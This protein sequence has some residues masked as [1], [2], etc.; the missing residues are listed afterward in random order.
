[1]VTKELIAALTEARR[2]LPSDAWHRLAREL[3][4]FQ[5]NPDIE[6]IE[7][8]ASGIANPDAAWI[9]KEAF[10]ESANCTE[11]NE[12]AATMMSVDYFVGDGAES[13]E[14]IWTGPSNNRFPM[15]RIDQALYDLISA[16]QR[17]IILVTFA[18]HRVPYLCAHLV[19]AVGRGVDLTLIVESEGESEGQLTLDAIAAFRGVPAAQ[20]RIYYWPLGRRE[21]NR[22]G[23]PGKLHAK[24]AIVDD[25]VLLGSANLTDDA[26]NRNMELGVLI[27]DPAPVAAIVEH[28]EDL[29]RRGVLTD[30]KAA[31]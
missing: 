19:Q 23:R 20:A 22:F 9:L 11:W 25:V 15:R 17:R 4:N 13:V 24:C 29:I 7:R 28:F 31:P 21:R 6:T 26:F 12:I 16:A 14:V 18:A 1:M 8:A 27:R 10:R 30:V 2:R 5:S 3:T